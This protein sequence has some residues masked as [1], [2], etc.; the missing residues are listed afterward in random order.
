MV[1]LPQSTEE[2]EIY[3][4]QQVIDLKPSILRIY[5]VYVLKD[6]KLYDMAKDLEYI[7]LTLKEAVKRTAKIYKIAI[8]ANINVIR[9]GLQTTEEINSKKAP[10]TDF[11]FS[12]RSFSYT[13]CNFF[14]IPLHYVI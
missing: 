7:P 13:S 2:K 14:S 12:N 4:I 11:L 6:S 8:E 3:T 10:T 9:I 5:P 1:G